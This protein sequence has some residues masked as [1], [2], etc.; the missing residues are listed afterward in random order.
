MKRFYV[1]MISLVLIVLLI[2]WIGP[3]Q[4]IDAFKTANWGLL[5][6]AMIIHLVAV[7]LRSIRWGFI[8]NKPKEFKN[9][10]VVKTIGLFAGNFSPVRTAGEPVT[11]IAGKK[12]NKISLSEGLSA[13]LTERFFDF[14]IVGLLLLISCIWLPKIRYLAIIG[15]ILSLSF[16]VLI[17]F[18]NW[19]ENASIWLYEKIHPLIERLPIQEEVLDNFYEKA[20]QLLKSM[21]TYTKSFTTYKNLILVIILSALSW[22][23][24]CLRLLTV[25]Y[26]FNLEISFVAVI[27]IFLLA[28]II[29]VV[30]V[31]PGGIGSIEISLTGLF[32][33]FGVPRALSGSIALADR[34]VSFWVV[35][36]LG[37]IFS[38]YYAKDI[39]D[40]IKKF[41]ID[42]KISKK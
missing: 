34:L 25:F 19:R 17:Y 18:I 41:S 22:L 12:I 24:E 2:L 21:V 13:G 40:E 33:L 28:N 30:T 16:V 9:N 42:L 27:I 32:V 6:L 26:A 39:F 37:L 4:I 14:I 38:F 8:I 15:G 10:F 20:V 36:V 7:G 11:A 5:I 35:T 23:V 31:L 1:F 3:Q 29:G